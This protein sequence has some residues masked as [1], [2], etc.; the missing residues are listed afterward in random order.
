M[1]WEVTPTAVA[2]HHPLAR[3]GHDLSTKRR[4][5][6]CTRWRTPE[7]RAPPCRTAPGGCVLSAH[8]AGPNLLRSDTPSARVI[9]IREVAEPLNLAGQRH[10]S[11]YRCGVRRPRLRAEVAPPALDALPA[12][13]AQVYPSCVSNCTLPI[14]RGVHARCRKRPFA[15]CVRWGT[16]RSVVPEGKGV[17]EGVS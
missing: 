11:D 2:N 1:S 5:A 12:L 14:E 4:F 16:P 10:H 13:R 15:M 17:E 7:S 8:T 6:S 9:L 3:G